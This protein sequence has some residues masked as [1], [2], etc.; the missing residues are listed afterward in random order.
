MGDLRMICKGSSM[1]WSA[2]LPAPATLV[3][4]KCLIQ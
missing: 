4:G 3:I 1:K 2:V